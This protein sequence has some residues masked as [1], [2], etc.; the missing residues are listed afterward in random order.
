MNC[1]LLQLVNFVSP[2]LDCNY[3]WQAFRPFLKNR[4]FRGRWINSSKRIQKMVILWMPRNAQE[5]CNNAII[6][7]FTRGASGRGGWYVRRSTCASFFC[8]LEF[9][10]M[11]NAQVCSTSCGRQNS[12]QP[13]LENPWVDLLVVDW[14]FLFLIIC[15]IIYLR[16]IHPTPIQIL[17]P[18]AC[19][20]QASILSS[21]LTLPYLCPY[22]LH[23]ARLRRR[24]CQWSIVTRLRFF[25]PRLPLI[26]RFH[27]RSCRPLY[28]IITLLVDKKTLWSPSIMHLQ[29]PCRVTTSLTLLVDKLQQSLKDRRLARA[30]RSSLNPL[31]I[32]T[33]NQAEPNLRLSRLQFGDIAHSVFSWFR[34]QWL[35]CGIPRIRSKLLGV[36]KFLLMSVRLLLVWLFIEILLCNKFERY[37]L[38]CRV[39]EQSRACQSH[40][41]YQY[42]LSSLPSP[43]SS[44]PF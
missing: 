40:R 44:T 43:S 6:N 16:A 26:L 25:H 4:K 41:L 1:N 19:K 30:D 29:L 9:Y 35:N 17:D 20:E 11:W 38:P 18:L 14:R 5:Y 21:P 15:R 42:S 34:L 36:W 28:T 12:K 2:T 23:R 37:V 31:R 7:I 27:W 10:L 39:L 3:S 32:F 33:L 13:V 22:L 8:K 24:I